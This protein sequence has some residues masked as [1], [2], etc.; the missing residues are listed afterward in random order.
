MIMATMTSVDYVK[1]RSLHFSELLGGKT[2]TL[3]FVQHMFTFFFMWFVGRLYFA[4]VT[5][6]KLKQF[7]KKSTPNVQFIC[8]DNEFVYQS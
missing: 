1:E 6:V 5:E 7:M 3:S 4:T 8:T 2:T